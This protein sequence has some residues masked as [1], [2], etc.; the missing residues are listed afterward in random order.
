MKEYISD[1]KYVVIDKMTVL[2][3]TMEGSEPEE[4]VISLMNKLADE[5]GITP[6]RQ[7]GFDSPVETELDAMEYR[8][9]EYWLTVSGEDLD[10][11]PSDDEFDYSGNTVTIKDIPGFRYATIRIEDPFSEPFERIP[12]GWKAL[13]GWLEEHDFKE[14]DFKPLTDANCLEEVLNIDDSTVMDIF[15]PVD[16]C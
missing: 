5:Y 15:I 10:K 12:G 8:A 6:L 11:L 7:F 9:Y 4:A 1:V 3:C 16:I 13:V 14:P 2:S